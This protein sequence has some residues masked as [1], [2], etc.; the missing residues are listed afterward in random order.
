MDFDCMCMGSWKQG[1]R[2]TYSAVANESLNPK[3]KQRRTRSSYFGG[4][5]ALVVSDFC[6]IKRDAGCISRYARRSCNYRKGRH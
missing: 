4:H 1:V 3:T 5:P 6:Q 2:G